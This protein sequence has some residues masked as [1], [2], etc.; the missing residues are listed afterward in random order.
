[1]RG[2]AAL[3]Q[4]VSGQRPLALAGLSSARLTPLP[5]ITSHSENWTLAPSLSAW[6]LPLSPSAATAACHLLYWV[7][8]VSSGAVLW[9]GEPGNCRLLSLAPGAIRSSATVWLSS[10]R[11]SAECSQQCGARPGQPGTPGHSPGQR[12][13]F[14][15]Q[16]CF[17]CLAIFCSYLLI[18]IWIKYTTFKIQL[19]TLFNWICPNLPELNIIFNSPGLWQLWQTQVNF[20]WS[21][22]LIQSSSHFPVQCHISQCAPELPGQCTV[23]TERDPAWPLHTGI[24]RGVSF[25]LGSFSKYSC[26][27]VQ[28]PN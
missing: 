28:I 10:S 14:Q 2:Q 25:H 3:V 12:F 18:L 27:T 11:V 24:T 17:Y 7:V 16:Y 13:K 5:Q 19:K 23:D 26:N 6:P 21:S 22:T 15:I 9:W 8:G 1:M 4:V 20:T